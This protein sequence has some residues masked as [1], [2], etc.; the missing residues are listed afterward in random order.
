KGITLIDT[1]NNQDFAKGFLPNSLNIENTKSMA[2]W[3]GWI[4]NYEEQF[5]L[6]IEEDQVE[7][8]TRKLM[9]IG[10]DNVL[11]Y[12][13]SVKDLGIELQ[14]ADYIHYDAFKNYVGQPNVQIVDVRSNSEYK[15]GHV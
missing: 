14:T 9:R 5:M 10:L 7:E 13:T 2:T 11:G 1:R 3:A 4:L 8:V 12:I 6:V 15:T